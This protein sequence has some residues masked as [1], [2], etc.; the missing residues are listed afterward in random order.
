[1]FKKLD[2]PDATPEDKRT[3][4]LYRVGM[5]LEQA[6]EFAKLG[7][8]EV[9]EMVDIARE[10]SGNPDSL[11]KFFNSIQKKLKQTPSTKK[12]FCVRSTTSASSLAWPARTL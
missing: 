10:S 7:D 1:M 3:A 11:R 5:D 8:Q 6:R 9:N 4:K 2:G 12:S